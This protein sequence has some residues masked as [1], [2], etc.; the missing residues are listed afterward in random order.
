MIEINPKWTPIKYQLRTDLNAASVKTKEKLVRKSNQAVK[1]ILEI[2]AP[3]Q[4][5]T[6]REV[7]LKK[8]EL[9]S[10]GDMLKCLQAA[11]TQS[12]CSNDRV[13]AVSVL[14]AKD[15]DNKYIYTTAELL[16]L[17]PDTSKHLIEKARVHA[18]EGQAGMPIEAGKYVKKRLTNAQV[19]HFLDFLQFSGVMQDVASGTR[20]VKLTSARKVIMPNVVR[21]VH[22]SEIV[23]LYIAASEEEGYTTANGRPSVR[24]IWNML[25]NCPASQRK[26]LSGLDNVTADG[27]DSFGLL[28]KITA[29]LKNS[30]GD[31]LN[32]LEIIE[33][34]LR[35]EKKY[36]KGEYK[37]NCSNNCDDI[38]D[39]CR[40]FA[41][42]DP[43]EKC[44]QQLCSVQHENHCQN[45]ETLAACLKD[46]K[47]LVSNMDIS[48]RKKKED[49]LYD[50]DDASCR[51]FA[52]K[53]H[54]LATVHQEM[55]QTD[56]LENLS[57]DTAILIV[58][59]AM[60]FLA[61]R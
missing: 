43:K 4:C 17:F 13:Q 40:I 26:S 14:C 59:F 44:Y 20:T 34:Q 33:K 22:K 6:L 9:T 42:S 45:C 52:W 24:T 56:I 39:H 35:D 61:R 15:N 46:L 21:T 2:I 29:E 51:I 55:Q 23:R 38:S 31:L 11:V 54:I 50:N 49:L 16:K 53:A 27:S 47:N 1:S 28:L 5:E 8:T 37:I 41:L 18:A 12:H 10:D 3:G 60:K 7:C 32:E 57:H 19:N 58:D 48:N 36:T 25:N 30:H